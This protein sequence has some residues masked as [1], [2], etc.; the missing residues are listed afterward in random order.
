MRPVRLSH[1]T[2]YNI[3]LLARFAS[4][5]VKEGIGACCA[6]QR[7]S[8]LRAGLLVRP[9]AS[10]SPNEVGSQCGGQSLISSDDTLLA[11]FVTFRRTETG[12]EDCYNLTV[13][14]CSEPD[15]SDG[16]GAPSRYKYWRCAST[17]CVADLKQDLW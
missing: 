5:T 17:G 15:A 11:S 16:A 2:L 6:E 4:R 14:L 3:A 12:P 9:C 8:R 1:L 13:R 10:R 7:A